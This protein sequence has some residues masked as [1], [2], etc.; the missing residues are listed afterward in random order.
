[1]T[2]DEI[3]Q[4][5]P[6]SCGDRLAGR[7]RRPRASGLIEFAVKKSSRDSLWDR[8]GGSA[9]VPPSSWSDDQRRSAPCSRYGRR[10][11]APTRDMPR[12]AAATATMAARGRGRSS[13]SAASCWEKTGCRPGW[14]RR[15]GVLPSTTAFAVTAP[16]LA[17]AHRAATHRRGP[18]VPHS[19][20]SAA[21]DG[22]SHAYWWRLP[23]RR[24]GQSPRRCAA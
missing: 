3:A 1:M 22:T 10:A 9:H 13:R 23:R 5:V 21:A 4:D 17:S 2:Q 16:C 18:S 7:I 14:K 11:G 19:S 20:P 15:S 6:R 24:T 8:R 12:R